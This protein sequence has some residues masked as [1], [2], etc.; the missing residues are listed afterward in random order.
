MLLTSW[1]FHDAKHNFAACLGK[2]IET[3]TET[4]EP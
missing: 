1:V 4:D 2:M 3:E